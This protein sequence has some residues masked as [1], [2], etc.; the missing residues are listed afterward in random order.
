MPGARVR[1]KTSEGDAGYTFT[2]RHRKMPILRTLTEKMD[3]RM[4]NSP[5]FPA[6]IL[7]LSLVTPAR[8]Q[9]AAAEPDAVQL[10]DIELI[11]FARL[12]AAAANSEGWPEDPGVPDYSRA[13]AIQEALTPGALQL[14]PPGQHLLGAEAARLA[15]SGRL[16]PLLHLAWRQPGL[17]PGR[18]GPVYLRS[19]ETVDGALPRLEGTVTITRQ[20]YLHADL[21]LLLR[22]HRFVPGAGSLFDKRPGYRFVEHRKMRSGELHYIDHPLA[23]ALIKI[24][25]Y[26][27]PEPPAPPQAEPAVPPSEVRT[28]PPPPS[29]G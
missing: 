28:A 19:A 15:R 24:E 17:E 25:K 11:L 23:G 22:D 10:Y 29:G 9:Q 27:P 5:L 3:S 13:F 20:R 6:L 8:A 18:A 26:T 14:L 16:E 7:L 21:D 2:F 1:S 12:G 4:R